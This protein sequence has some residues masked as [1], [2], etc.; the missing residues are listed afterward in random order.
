MSARRIRL[1]ACLALPALFA[2]C[3][4]SRPAIRTYREVAAA[5]PTP[6]AR[7]AD[8]AAMSRAMPP[9]AGQPPARG[10]GSMGDMASMPVQGGGVTLRWTTP[11]GWEE[12]AGN[13]MR[14]AT[15]LVGPDRAECTIASFPGEVGGLEANLRRWAGQLDATVPDDALARF[16]RSPETFES[17]G[18]LP[19]LVFDFAA[20]LPADAPASMLA[21]VVP[22]EGVTVF[23]KLMG[24]PALLAE[25]KAAFASLCRSLRP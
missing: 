21:A 8:V 23:V 10:G 4:E 14:M 12:R 17:E 20:L 16:A 25:Q 24:R 3:G 9:E 18:G 2:G 7:A 5:E 1:V 6:D 22:M 15:F 13:A 19:C 11:A